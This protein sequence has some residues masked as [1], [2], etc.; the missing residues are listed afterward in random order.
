MLNKYILGETSRRIAL[1]LPNSD[2]KKEGNQS[3]T[4][5]I[6]HAYTGH[7]SMCVSRPNS[8]RPSCNRGLKLYQPQKGLIIKQKGHTNHIH[9]TVKALNDIPYIVVAQAAI[10]E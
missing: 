7:V 4:V 2:K 5:N 3:S 10:E 1:Q 6:H 9:Q 8:G